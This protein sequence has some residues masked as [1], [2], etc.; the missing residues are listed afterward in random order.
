MQTFA[1]EVDFQGFSHPPLNYQLGLFISISIILEILCC[2]KKQHFSAVS[3]NWIP[4]FPKL[5]IFLRKV[6]AQNLWPNFITEFYYR[7]FMTEFAKTDEYKSTSSQKFSFSSR[8]P[9]VTQHHQGYL[10]FYILIT[11]HIF[12]FLRKNYYI[13]KVNMSLSRQDISHIEIIKL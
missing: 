4:K 10:C 11:K 9:Q 13:I 7:N 5:R 8:S 2:V 6:C 1:S 12:I 3:F